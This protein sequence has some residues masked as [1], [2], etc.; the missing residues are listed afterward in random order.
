M[1]KAEEKKV[2]MINI[3]LILKRFLNRWKFKKIEQKLKQV[4]YLTKHL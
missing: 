3:I 2:I 1:K 4:K